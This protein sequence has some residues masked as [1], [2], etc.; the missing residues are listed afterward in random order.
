ME[1]NFKLLDCTFRDGGYYND[2]F[3]DKT[4]VEE[5][6]AVL[7]KLPIDFCE[8]GFRKYPDSPSLGDNLYTTEDYI[9]TL[10]TPQD[11]KLSLMCML[12]HFEGLSDHQIAQAFVPKKDSKIDLIRIASSLMELSQSIRIGNLVKDLGYQV[13]LNI[14]HVSTFSK[15]SIRKELKQ[16]AGQNFSVICFADTMGNM[17]PGDIDELVK[18]TREYYEGELGCHM[19]DNRGFAMENSLFSLEKGMTWVDATITGM[20]RGAG[21]L[22]LESMLIEMNQRFEMNLDLGPLLELNEKYFWPMKQ[23]Y[24]WGYNPYYH[25]GSVIGAHPFD[26]QKLLANRSLS[27]EQKM[28]SIKKGIRAK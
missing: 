18:V 3:F 23:A 27:A 20:G 21:N 16:L 1:K 12:R 24:G 10:A 19:H 8:I 15:E 17:L 13:S 28:D 6:L 11:L 4:L 9:N 7:A 26:T 22:I 2:W 25:L 5:T 14:T